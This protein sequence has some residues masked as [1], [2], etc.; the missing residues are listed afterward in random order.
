MTTTTNTQNTV[1]TNSMQ[2]DTNEICEAS[3]M[4]PT[5]HFED[6]DDLNNTDD[7]V[8]SNMMIAMIEL[9]PPLSGSE[10]QGLKKAVLSGNRLRTYYLVLKLVNHYADCLAETQEGYESLSTAESL[11]GRGYQLDAQG[12][13]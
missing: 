10:Q 1:N 13:V 12:A 3:F 11:E 7:E 4:F 8:F 9:L 6:A 2:W 5:P